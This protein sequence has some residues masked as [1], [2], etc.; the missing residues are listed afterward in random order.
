MPKN[1]WIVSFQFIFV[2]LYMHIRHETIFSIRTLLIA[3]ENNSK[4]CR[5]LKTKNQFNFYL[6]NHE[7]VKLFSCIAS[8]N[9]VKEYVDTIHHT[10]S[11]KIRIIIIIIMYNHEIL[12]LQN[13]LDIQFSVVYVFGSYIWSNGFVIRSFVLFNYY[14]S[15]ICEFLSSKM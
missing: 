12:L 2:S 13:F 1:A 9:D 6:S 15:N 8:H 14:V 3:L 10:I 5:K 4:Q 11:L 7:N